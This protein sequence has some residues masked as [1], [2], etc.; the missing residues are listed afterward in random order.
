MKMKFSNKMYQ[1]DLSLMDA[2]EWKA[3][4]KL[5]DTQLMNIAMFNLKID[6]ENNSFPCEI[7]DGSPLPEDDRLALNNDFFKNGWNEISS[8]NWD[9]CAIPESFS[10]M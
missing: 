9:S 2:Y 8:S 3:E 1:S 10:G 7:L 6:W 4:E 5:Q